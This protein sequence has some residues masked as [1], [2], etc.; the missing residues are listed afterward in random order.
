[1]VGN[2]SLI[3]Q[4]MIIVQVQEIKLNM[5]AQHLLPAINIDLFSLIFISYTKFLHGNKYLLPHKNEKQP[6]SSPN[7]YQIRNIWVMNGWYEI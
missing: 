6:F 2:E 7:F 4:R 1:M 5:Q 3:N